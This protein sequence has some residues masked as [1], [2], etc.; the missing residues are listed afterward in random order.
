MF[1]LSM[2]LT[3]PLAI[4]PSA[5]QVPVK[6]SHSTMLWPM[7]VVLITGSTGSAL[8]AVSPFQPLRHAVAGAISFFIAKP[9]LYPASRRQCD[10]GQRHWLPVALSLCHQGPRHSGELVGQRDGCDFDRAALE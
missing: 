6:T 5:D 1:G 7:W 2:R 10:L 3:W 8:R 9:L 4:M